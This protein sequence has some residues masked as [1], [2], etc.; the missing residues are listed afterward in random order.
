MDYTSIKEIIDS[1]LHEYIDDFQSQ[2]NS[3]GEAIF[4]DFFKM[5]PVVESFQA[6]RMKSSE[7]S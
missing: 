1:G 2:L 4:E 7:R 6:Q 5:R 3:V